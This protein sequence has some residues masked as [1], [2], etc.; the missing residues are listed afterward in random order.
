M[1]TDDL[2]IT[3]ASAGINP[4]GEAAGIAENGEN[5]GENNIEGLLHGGEHL[6]DV[7]RNV[8]RQHAR[9]AERLFRTTVVDGTTAQ[10]PRQALLQSVVNQG[11]KRPRP[12]SW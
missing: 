11:L 7:N 8:R 3:S 4:G 2:A 6:D 1:A 10:L 9:T 12:R 5:N